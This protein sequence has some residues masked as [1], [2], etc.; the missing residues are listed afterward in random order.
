MPPRKE[1]ESLRRGQNLYLHPPCRTTRTAD[2]GSRASGGGT[3]PGALF[4]FARSDRSFNAEAKVAQMLY[5]LTRD[6]PARC[7]NWSALG[8][9]LPLQG[10]QPEIAMSRFP[11]RR[12]HLFAAVLALAAFLP[13][14]PVSAQSAASAPAPDPGP[15]YADLAGAARIVAM[16]TVQKAAPL[17]PERAG[18]VSPGHARVYI[19]A[20]TTALLVGNG[21][22]ESVAYLA[23][24]PLDARGKVPKLKKQQVIL[25]ARP[26]PDRP[27]ELALVATDAQ[28]GWTP[29]REAATRAILTEMLSPDA[30]PRIT[31]VREALYTPGNLSGEGETQIFL[32]TPT[33]RTVSVSVLRRP[34]EAPR[35]G[36]SLTEIVDQASRPPARD[37]LMWYRLA[38]FLPHR[39]PARANISEPGAQAAQAAT[40]YALVMDQLGPCQRNRAGGEPRQGA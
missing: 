38:C 21:L 6:S 18:N 39:L 40:D 4:S 36:V 2:N 28:V 5:R 7:L 37:T 34:G 3:L 15:T 32:S 9:I 17:P 16:A 19:E 27:D 35:W 22:G 14:S 24:V 8:L 20:R 30:P 29:A 11:P 1:R 12:R 13:D 33:S 26:V 10:S 31:G 25:F 23:D